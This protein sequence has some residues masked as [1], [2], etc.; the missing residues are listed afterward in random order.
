MTHDDFL[1]AL[2]EHPDDDA[3]RL[4]FA[5]WFEEHGEPERAEFIRVQ[6]ELAKL[7][8]ADKRRP[9]LEKRQT[10]LL[11]RN[12]EAWVRPIRDRVLSWTF[13]RGFVAEVA[14]TV[15]AYMKY[16]FE[17]VRLTPLRRM[18]VDRMDVEIR[19]SAMKLVPESIARESLA[20]PL[21]L[22][23]DHD[24]LVATMPSPID[25]DLVTKLN[26]ILNRNIA[27]VEGASEQLQLAINRH[28]GQQ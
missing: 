6:I 16:T 22:L 24:A 9:L 2:I 7:P 15:D 17:L 25:D 21:G 27:A 1:Q 19:A 28:Y 5:D 4:V 10:D 12:E 20:V 26:F 8:N 13:H 14:L 11:A 23:K 18:W 3:L